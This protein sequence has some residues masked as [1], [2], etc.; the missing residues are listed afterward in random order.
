MPSRDGLAE[1][2][3]RVTETQSSSSS[4]EAGSSHDIGFVVIGRNEGDRLKSALRAITLL[5]DA[6]VIVYVDSG[7]SDNSVDFAR[8]LAINVVEL[9]MSI[10]FTAARA[11]N[12][13]FARLME[14]SDSIAFVQ[15]LD[16]D[17]ELQP[18]WLQ[19]A[20][21]VLTKTDEV[22]VVSGRRYERF[23]E[24]SIYNT[25]IDIEWDTPVGE[26]LAVL[27]D[28]CV[29][30]SVFREVGGFSEQIIAAEDD[31][32]CLRVRDHGYKVMRIDTEM[33]VH[34][35]NMSELSQ[36]FRRAKRGGHGYANIFR[37]HGNGPSHYFRREL[38]S[39]VVWGAII[40][41]V[42]VFSIFVYPWLAA[43]LVSLYGVSLL[44]TTARIVGKGHSYKVAVLYALL[45]NS[46]KIWEFQGVIQYWVNHL[47]SRKHRLIEYK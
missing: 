33:S 8:S 19:A 16:G 2:E 32:F 28:M 46:G 31:D 15:F 25:L 12:A 39:T 1:S 35:A 30:A 43:L 6:S 23:P 44:R 3:S 37:I 26:A 17:C 4:T 42:F 13:G 20:H 14:L 18:E 10:P 9:D 5:S 40:P 45:V 7:S 47:L 22:A 34:D 36:W 21:Q 41:S 27:G 11:R 24:A 38:A 29:K